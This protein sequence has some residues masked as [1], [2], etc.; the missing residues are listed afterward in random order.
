VDEIFG[1]LGDALAVLVNRLEER[2]ARVIV[3]F[4]EWRSTT[5]LGVVDGHG[6]GRAIAW[7]A[8]DASLD[9]TVDGVFVDVTGDVAVDVSF[10]FKSN[11]RKRA[12]SASNC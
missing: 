9:D 5:K 8:I 6:G 11:L 12:S 1:V 7:K 4:W 3:V 10:L 2:V